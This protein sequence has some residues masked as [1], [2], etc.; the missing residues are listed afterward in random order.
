MAGLTEN[1]PLALLAIKVPPHAPVN[2][3]QLAP[4]P[5]EPPLTVRVLLPPEHKVAGDAVTEVGFTE[6]VFTVTGV[7]AHAVVLQSPDAFT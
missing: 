4:V 3:C 2:N 7:L 6:L 1:I 5:S